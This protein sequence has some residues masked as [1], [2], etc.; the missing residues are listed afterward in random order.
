MAQVIFR[1]G[2]SAAFTSL[3]VK[4]ENSLYFLTDSQQIYKGEQLVS[5][6]TK[7]NV[8]FT[9]TEPTP[10]DAQEDMLYVVTT[11]EGTGIYVKSEET[12]TQV[13]GGEAQE[14]ADGIVS[15]DKLAPGLVATDLSSPS[16]TTIPTTKAV[17][18]AIQ[19]A[20][21][22]ID[23]T[24][25]DA[26]FTGVSTSAA[27]G[28]ESGT[29]LTFTRKA[30]EP[31]KVTI[32]DLFLTNAE[33][34]PITH[35]L[36]LTVGDEGKQVVVSLEDLVPQAVTTSDVAMADTIT[37]TTPVGNFTKGQVVDMDDLQSFLVA[38][39]S[40]DSNPTV[41]QPSAS[42]TLTG[43]G[44]KEVGT[45]F[46]PQY[47]ANLNPGAYSDN[48][49]G[50][51][52]TGVT[53]TS[54]AVT[55]TNT[56][57]A[58]TQT[59]S[60]TAFT[61]EDSTNYRVSVTVNYGD[62]NIPTT[63]L[64]EPY[65]D[66][67]I[68]AGSKT[69]QSASVTGYRNVFWGYKNGSNTIADPTAITAT[70]IK[71]LGNANRNKPSTLAT[72]QMQQMF[73]ALPKGQVSGLAIQASTGLPQTVQGPITVQV[74]GVSDYSPTAYDVFYVSNAIAEAGSETYTL[75]WN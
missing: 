8:T 62:G 4:D 68:K 71:A 61:V 21:D 45:Q 51:Q 39:L 3:P 73:F 17:S 36:T 2:T 46:T 30:G 72:N 26:A 6:V 16:D 49:N 15:I 47:S 20:I 37:V 44:A 48:K 58:D 74:G 24:P 60:F 11:P 66:G 55:D 40:Q 38:M 5:D 31:V 27:S 18:D 59:G 13:G 65:P 28:G 9:A 32:A 22:E 7:L 10:E 12:I 69:A 43:A 14:I 41:T 23:L 63:F 57:S 25:Y 35:N 67:Q 19:A 1:Y 42:I 53:A 56:G 29:I 54:W 75:T 64:G 33:Y 34:D 50:A 52:P 70:E